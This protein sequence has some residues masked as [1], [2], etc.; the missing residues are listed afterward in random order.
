[1]ASIGNGTEASALST[2][3]TSASVASASARCTTC[4][5][6]GVAVWYTEERNAT[7]G[8]KAFIVTRIGDTAFG[9]AIVWMFQLTGTI[10]ITQ[11]NAMGSL[12][13]PTGVLSQM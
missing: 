3:S 11:L 4:L 13:I 8:R 12:L 7:A 10:S 2:R 5:S 1:M 9:I 6:L